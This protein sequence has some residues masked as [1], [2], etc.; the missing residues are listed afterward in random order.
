MPQ[1]VLPPT[2]ESFQEMVDEAN[3]K[4]AQNPEV[5]YLVK[6]IGSDTYLAGSQKD[7]SQKINTVLQSNLV[8]AL[9]D[10]FLPSYLSAAGGID[11][12]RVRGTI[13]ELARDPSVKQE[14][15]GEALR[16][17][18]FTHVESSFDLLLNL[19]WNDAYAGSLVG[20]SANWVMDDPEIASRKI[21]KL[22]GQPAYDWAVAGLVQATRASDP[23][24]AEKWMREIK[25]PD[26]L[27]QAKSLT[28]T[29]KQKY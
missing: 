2:T 26:A 17:L 27:T 3:Q 13:N 21:A 28:Y 10:K 11:F 6:L 24:S 18:S 29:F 23:P 1:T 22:K 7:D 20:I 16:Q 19:P 15:L 8:Q 4:Y 12:E 9:K 5:M 14:L 25:D